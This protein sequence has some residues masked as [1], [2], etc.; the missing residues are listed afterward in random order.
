MGIRTVFN[1]LGPL[2]NPACANAQLVGV[3]DQ[4]LTVSL[5]YALNSLSCEEA[6]IVHGLDGLDEVSTIGKTAIAWLREGEVA[7]LETAPKDFGVPQATADAVKGT[8]PEENAEVLFRILHGMGAAES[9]KR[10]IV[11]V[12]SAAGVIVG[13]E[14]EDFIYAM[15]VARESIDSGAAYKRLRMLVKASG[16][17]LARLEELE[18]KY[19]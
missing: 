15:D 13:R 17:D 12:N 6:M 11:L 7:T 14:A 16:G 19:A 8:T 3:Y 10:D 2:T 18:K 1:L 4:A 9:A 5:A